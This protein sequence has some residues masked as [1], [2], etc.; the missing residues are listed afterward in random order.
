MPPARLRTRQLIR[1]YWPT[2]E[3]PPIRDE[4][5]DPWTL[6]S[7]EENKIIVLCPPVGQFLSNQPQCTE[8]SDTGIEEDADGDS[9]QRGG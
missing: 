6:L 9:V 4:A 2:L 5:R 1:G 3:D 8:V 7:R